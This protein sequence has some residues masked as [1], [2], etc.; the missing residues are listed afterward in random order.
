MA[1][2]M[3]RTERHGGIVVIVIDNPPVN[4]LSTA[5]R[6]GIDDAL[7]AARRDDEVEAIVLRGAGDQF[8]AGADIAEFDQPPVAPLLPD[9]LDRIEAGSKPTVAA[10]HG[11]CFGG[12][13]E[14]ALS[15]HYRVAVPS[16]RLG[17]PEVKIGLSP[18]AGG[19]QRLPRLAGVPTALAM[20]VG[21]DPVTADQAV[22][23]GLIDRI[24][25]EER[26]GEDAV[27]FAREVAVPQGPRRTCERIVE[28]PADLF[29]IAL[30]RQD[31]EARARVAP[32]ACIEAIR[33]AVGLPFRA[34]LAR[35]RDL[36]VALLAGRESMALRHLFFAEQAASKIDGVMAGIEPMPVGKVGIVGAGT[37]GGGIAMNFLSVGL[38][39]V[40]VEREQ[41]ALQHG[42]ATIRKNYERSA[43][44]GRITAGQ[45]EAAMGKLLPSLRLEDLA[46]C[47]LVIEA[48]FENMDIKR[49]VFRRLDGIARHG[50]ILASN[51]SFLDIDQL[52]SMT[53]RPG[54]VL[55]MHFFSPANVM[56]LLEIVRGAKTAPEVLA[57][58]M[59][60]SRRMG[61]VAVV[62]GVC[63]GFI[64]NRM[65]EPR[66][67]QAHALMMEGAT[68]SDIDRALIEF[69]MP[70]GPFQMA[71]LAGLDIGWDAATSSGTTIRDLLCEQGR[72]GQ[73]NGHGFYDYDA[74]RNGTASAEV[75]AMIRD[76]AARRG[77]PQRRIGAD[78]IRERLLYTM[79]N[80][81]AKILEEGIARRASDIDLV[82]VHGYGWPATTGGPLFWADGIGLQTIIDGLVSHRD[83]LGPDAVVSNLLA[84]KAAS[85]ETFG[86]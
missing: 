29:E 85:R 8:S 36:F 70:M 86:A 56:R 55:G 64:G 13:L 18:G 81:A 73:K 77:Y 11:T 23:T 24:V 57:T 65:L 26:L 45:V 58:A 66:Q 75:E 33:A 44:R 42:V 10:L 28:A 48:V 21:G 9:M 43:Q 40:L 83:R 51:T 60:L 12:G 6:R 32:A 27:L 68:P 76:F 31:R 1:K 52:A 35:E 4:L 34:G 19:T 3:I 5:I 14:L 17:L 80:E 25:S 79:I 38:D 59:S 37:M 63:H 50:A 39:V 30:A 47:D 15:C 74:R 71:D 46:D 20:I 16:A 54:H 62:A 67:R 82:W 22:S 84:R 72:R 2:S 53:T 41:A 61:K 49:D 7:A 69:G 78:E